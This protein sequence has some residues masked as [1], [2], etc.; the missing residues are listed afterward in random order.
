[1]DI[2]LK[3]EDHGP[4]CILKKETIG[5]YMYIKFIQFFIIFVSYY[6]IS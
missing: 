3:L 4:H 5:R 1:M 2:I 6:I